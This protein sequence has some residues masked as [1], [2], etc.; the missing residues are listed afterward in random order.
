MHHIHKSCN[1]DSI[2]FE[3]RFIFIIFFLKKQIQIIFIHIKR[4]FLN[5]IYYKNNIIDKIKKYIRK[6]LFVSKQ[7]E[8]IS[9]FISEMKK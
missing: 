3:K 6:H 5:L 4:I 2:R 8:N 9:E 7:K 1:I